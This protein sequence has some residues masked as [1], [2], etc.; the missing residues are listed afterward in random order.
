[1]NVLV[2]GGAG[3]IGSHACYH[4]KQK[5]FHPIVVDSLERGH[6]FFVR[7]GDFYQLNLL[8][9]AA[10][11]Q[12]FQK[13]KIDCVIHFAAYAYVQESNEKP[14]M[15]LENNVKG[16][17]TLLDVMQEEKVNKLVFS[18][19]CSVYGNKTHS[20]PLAETE[21]VSPMNVY[22]YSKYLAEQAIIAAPQIKS[23]ILRYFNAAG[24]LP[25][26]R[27]GEDHDPETRL[28]PL[29]IKAAEDPHFVLK[30]F[31]QDYPTND[32]TAIRDYIHVSDLANAHIKAM[33]YLS[34][35][36]P[37]TIFNLGTEKGNS[38]LD[39]IN[40]VEK[41]YGKTCKKEIYPRREGDPSSLVADAAKAK[42]ELGWVPNYS[43]TQTVK[44]A[45]DWYLF[46]SKQDN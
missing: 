22:A 12:V 39:V 3:Y 15:Y 9:K 42:N 5:G 16:V 44:D 29:A 6:K 8:D 27:L 28:I 32:G 11:Q 34:K 33:D 40:T 43:F 35:D 31:G 24:G 10:L 2:T 37:S 25:Q 45:Y 21:S 38:V 13:H 46:K 41:T 20:H 19:T 30:V 23:V 1:M 18:S 7:W 4:L 14:Q 26:E 36:K 17:L